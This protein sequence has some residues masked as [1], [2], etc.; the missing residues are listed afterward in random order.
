M[1]LESTADDDARIDMRA[2]WA[3]IG[4]RWLRILLVTVVLLCGTYAVLLFVPKS[5]ESTS[6]ILVESRDSAFTRPA[7]DNS[8]TSSSGATETIDSIVS[9]QIELVKSRDTLLS[10]VHAENLTQVPEFNGTAS[11]PFNGITRLFRKSTAATPEDIAVAALAD[12]LTVIR[13]RDSTLIKITVR[14]GDPVL[15]ANLA[16]AIA[17]ADVARRAGQSLSDTAD[18]STWLEQQISQLR[19][20]V[21][22]AEN[23]VA[24]FKVA[25][26]L[27]TGTNSTSLIDQ[28]LT[29][30]SAQITAAQG[31]RSTAQSR[32]ALIRG[33][34][35][36]GQPIDGVDDVR[37]SVTI[38]QLMQQKAQLTSQKAQLLATLLPTHPSVEAVTAQIAA[39]DR[40]VAIEGRRV[41]D[42]LDAEAKI[43]AASIA[44]LQ[45]NL[46][47]IKAKAG[48]AT[49]Q[50]VTLDALDREAK[51]D[52]DL[53]ESYMTR[54]R[55]ATARTDPNAAL[56]DLRVLTYAAP[57]SAPAS[58]KTPLIL[59]AVAFVSLAVQLGAILFG[60]LLSG[61][62]LVE[63]EAVVDQE[64]GG[65]EA[66]PEEAVAAEGDAAML[67]PVGTPTA[68]P[69]VLVEPTGPEELPVEPKPATQLRRAAA[70]G[71]RSW[72]GKRARAVGATLTAYEPPP[73]ERAAVGPGIEAAPAAGGEAYYDVDSGA[74]L[75]SEAT[76]DAGLAAASEESANAERLANLSA[77]LILGRTHVLMLAGLDSSDDT[78]A[79]AERLVVDVLHRGLSI[80]RVDAGS[81]RPSTAPGITDLSVEQ[82]SFGDVVHKTAE[83]GLAEVP[84]GHLATLDRRSTRPVTLVE[85][86][87][88]IYEVVLVLTGRIGMASSL[89]LFAGLPCRLVL[90]AATA[91]EPARLEA[92]RA[93]AGA[94]GY[95][96]VEFIAAPTR[97]AQVA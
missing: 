11:S 5:Y 39:I 88:D 49:K 91:P 34:I 17:Q 90:V 12:H 79:L 57:S 64:A 44:S 69:P 80:A 15:A 89:P 16:N 9:S 62:A 22:D 14:S 85:A 84:W 93:D 1:A 67:E 21:A 24:N 95:D 47:D 92:A 68:E 19:Q 75:V 20:R 36:A 31:R 71:L 86:L 43:E 6:G 60:E 40:Q 45:K 38:Q 4:R 81:G 54:Y 58:P 96:V 72:F 76:M 61:R 59:G 82:A 26:D 28:Q 77:D 46:D 10:V 27:Y 25:N 2:L 87:S 51:A 35:A 48:D 29:D 94:L 23:K 56:P 42:A 33:L 13:E 37:N 73:V 74:P 18:A 78:Q 50:G 66:A 32:A 7:N 41:A 52:R 97:H 63:R 53:L 65:V 55:D 83:E 30:I 70:G 8:N 3:A